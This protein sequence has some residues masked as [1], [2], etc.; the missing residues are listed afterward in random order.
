[1]LD[2]SFYKRG[3]LSRDPI[4]LKDA[5]T[6]MNKAQNAATLILVAIASG[7]IVFLIWGVK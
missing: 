5:D 1:M 6:I 4:V 2:L 7:L 3:N